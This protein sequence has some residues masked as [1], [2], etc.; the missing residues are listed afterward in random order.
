MNC[1]AFDYPDQPLP[2]DILA[3]IGVPP[4]AGAGL[5]H[6]I[7][8]AALKL[9]RRFSPD[10]I[11][12]ILRR[13]VT[14]CGRHVP[15]TEIHDAV[16]NSASV[17]LEKTAATNPE[18]NGKAWPDV[19]RV[20][21]M[22]IASAIN[23]PVEAL[24]RAYDW[25]GMPPSIPECVSAMARILFPGDPLICA[26][27]E[28]WS[29]I[30]R[31]VSE[32]GT[33]LSSTALIVP[34]PM[35]AQTGLNKWGRSS[36]RCLQNTGPRRFLVIEFDIL[37][38]EEQAAIHNHLSWRYPLAL[39]LHSGGKSLHGWYYVAGVP[40]D[41]LRGFMN[42]AVSLGADPHSWTPCHMVRTPGGLRRYGVEF[43][44]QR[45]I[46]FNPTYAA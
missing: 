37:S 41:E 5:H 33:E 39:V 6:W 29:M 28:P 43:R 35:T 17:K 4:R 11:F 34:S 9:R 7:F 12:K 25:S 10:A 14:N 16:K 31:R 46:F 42:Y 32:W 19:D 36:T 38:I 21:V 27:K 3:L 15:D 30:C 24:E 13:A 44:L 26:G 45:P 8:L 20:A 40:E 1:N 23:R 18:R 22:R 2:P